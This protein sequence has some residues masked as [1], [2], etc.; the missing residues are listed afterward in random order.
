MKMLMPSHAKQ[1][2]ALPGRRTPLFIRHY[3][4]ENHLAA[5]FNPTVHLA[6]PAVISSSA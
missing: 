1:R 5:M 2:A 3:K 6:D 4:V